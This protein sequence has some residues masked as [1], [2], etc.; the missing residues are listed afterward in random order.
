VRRLSWLL[1]LTVP[2]CGAATDPEV[3][4]R[5]SALAFCEQ[6]VRDVLTPS[7]LLLPLR[8]GTR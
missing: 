6:S 3:K 8:P 1:L 4:D 2:A 7:P 5:A